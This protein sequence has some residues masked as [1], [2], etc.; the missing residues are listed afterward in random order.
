MLEEYGCPDNLMQLTCRA[1]AF[2]A[3]DAATIAVLEASFSARDAASI[4][5]G[6][7]RTCGA[8]HT[9]DGPRSIRTALN[10]RWVRP[11]DT[12]S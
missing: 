10:H 1:Q 9:A 7:N 6:A 5:L 2:D 4:F 8:N 11:R 3:P 12:S